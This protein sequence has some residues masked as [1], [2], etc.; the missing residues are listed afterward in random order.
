MV[1][2]SVLS[3]DEIKRIFDA[4]PN[5]KHKTILMTIYSAGLRVS[6]ASNL[7]VADIDSK[8]MQ[9]IVRQ[10]KGK[11][12]RYTLLSKSNLE[13]LR[14]YFKVYKPKLWLFFGI[15]P[16]EKLNNRTLQ[17]IFEESKIRALITKKSSL[18]TL[19]HSFATHLLEN[20]T[21][22]CYI[23]LLLGHACIQSTMVYLHLRRLDVLKVVS[24]LD[25]LM[26]TYKNIDLED[27]N[28]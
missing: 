22:L 25:I 4:T 9:I 5:L 28:D 19:R 13:V 1:L 21:D 23:Q 27:N 10:G 11:K 2:P 15:D 18:H 12:D 26:D 8:N 3:K 16:L 14:K 6:E 17:R 20:G 7:K 24:P